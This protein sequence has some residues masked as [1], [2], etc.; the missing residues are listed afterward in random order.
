MTFH[1]WAQSYQ[2]KYSHLG[3]FQKKSETLILSFLSE[4][5]EKFSAVV[6]VCWL[7][8]SLEMIF[9]TVSYELNQKNW[10]AVLAIWKLRNFTKFNYINPAKTRY[11]CGK[12]DLTHSV[13]IVTYKCPTFWSFSAM[14]FSKRFIMCN[15]W[16][17]INRLKCSNLLYITQQC[18]RTCYK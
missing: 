17:L 6:L 10:L 13:I 1:H 15:I 5:S 2:Q 4:K 12:N 14:S 3:H 18:L 16:E 11:Q 8:R 7:N 9:Q